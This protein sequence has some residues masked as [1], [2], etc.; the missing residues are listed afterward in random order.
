MVST[1][2][3]SVFGLLASRN[4]QYKAQQWHT[5]CKHPVIIIIIIITTSEIL[6]KIKYIYIY[7]NQAQLQKAGQQKMIR[8][9]VLSSYIY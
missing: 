9:N 7:K 5:T 6:Y 1:V 3:N 4:Q 2:F 8:T